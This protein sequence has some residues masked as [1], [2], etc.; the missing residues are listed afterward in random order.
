MILQVPFMRL[1]KGGL[2]ALTRTHT[3]SWPTGKQSVLVKQRRLRAFV[4][5]EGRKSR[6]EAVLR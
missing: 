4:T 6:K 1:Q 3:K 5:L 2:D